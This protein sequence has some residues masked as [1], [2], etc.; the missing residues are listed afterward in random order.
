MC[1]DHYPY[2]KIK[3]HQLLIL[4]WQPALLK[5]GKVQ[6]D[7]LTDKESKQA[8]ECALEII[9]C[10]IISGQNA[11]IQAMCGTI[12]AKSYPEEND[13]KVTISSNAADIFPVAP[14]SISDTSS[15]SNLSE[16]VF[17][18][19]GG[20]CYENCAVN[21]VTGK[22]VCTFMTKVD[23]YAGKLGYYQFEECGDAT[24][25]VLGLEVSKTYEFIQKDLS[26]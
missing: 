21:E 8:D 15:T 18:K 23:L 10:D 22:E 6:C 20:I 16:D 2:T 3:T 4:F 26:N 13:C 1:L 24:N 25:P 5:T 17:S 14:S 12:N 7:D 11:P 9:L 19:T